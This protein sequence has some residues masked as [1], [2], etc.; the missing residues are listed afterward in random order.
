MFGDMG[1]WVWEYAG[2]IQPLISGVGFKRFAVKPPVTEE[3]SSFAGEYPVEDGKIVWNWQ[4]TSGGTC[5]QLTVPAGCVAEV[6]LPGQAM[7][8]LPGGTYTLEW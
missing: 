3:L 2:G 6:T 4:K 8:I 7:Q 5:G 1:A